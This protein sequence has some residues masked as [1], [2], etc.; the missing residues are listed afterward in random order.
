MAEALPSPGR[1]VGPWR[2]LLLLAVLVATLLVVYLTPLRALVGEPGE[3]RERLDELGPAAPL[4]FTLAVAA[5]VALG[6]PRL[7]LCAAGGLAFGFLEGLVWAQVGTLIGS[8]A[9]F[10]FARWSGRDWLLQRFPA[11]ARLEDRVSRGGVWAVVLAR[12]IPAT[13]LFVNLALGFTRVRHRDFLLGTALGVLPE[14]VPVT[15]IGAG[16]AQGSPGQVTLYLSLA[17]AAAGLL[18]LASRRLARREDLPRWTETGA[19][20]GQEPLR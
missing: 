9:T 3:L 7:V 18:V 13:G 8:Y 14:A 11:L 10:L 4:A 15:L 19:E 5:L 20:T 2:P 1:R 16:V 12:Q 6:V 17:L